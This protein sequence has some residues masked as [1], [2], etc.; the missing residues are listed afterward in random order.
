MDL[1]EVIYQDLPEKNLSQRAVEIMVREILD[2]MSERLCQR[3]FFTI[4]NFGRWQVKH[5]KEK[6]G[7]HPEHQVPIQIPSYKTVTFKTSAHLSNKLK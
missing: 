6:L 2:H 7:H 1:V 3:G 4:H 5:Y